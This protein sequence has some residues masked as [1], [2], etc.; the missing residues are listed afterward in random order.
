[1]C[2]ALTLILS[3]TSS[4]CLAQS[5]PNGVTPRPTPPAAASASP[6]LS[7]DERTRIELLESYQFLREQLRAAQVAIASNRIEAQE[8]ARRQN[9]DLTARLD[10][11]KASLILVNQ[12]QQETATRADYD[13]FQ[14]EQTTNRSHRTLLW[15]AGIAGGSVLLTLLM[16]SRFQWRAMNRI[17]DAVG[18][19]SQLHLTSGQYITDAH[20]ALPFDPAVAQANQRLM[21]AVERIERRVS[22]LEGTAQPHAPS[23][24]PRA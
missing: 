16:M 7:S 24:G 8:V 11:L 21:S 17:A 22:S 14:Q 13:R 23:R 19:Q 9:E 18:A 1:M 2:V 3:S 10:A 20:R 5:P 6:G 12:R 15:I 4:F